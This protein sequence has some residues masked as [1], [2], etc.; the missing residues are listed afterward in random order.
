M[1]QAIIVHL[2]LLFHI[3]VHSWSSRHWNHPENYSICPGSSCQPG[4]EHRELCHRQ[5]KKKVSTNFAALLVRGRTTS[6]FQTIAS[7]FLGEKHCGFWI[8]W[9]P[10]MSYLKDTVSL[11]LPNEHIR[12]VALCVL[13]TQL[14]L[15]FCDPMDCNLSGSSVRGILQARMLEWVATPLSRGIVPTQGL[16][17]S[18]PHHGQILYRLSYQGS[19]RVALLFEVSLL[20][21]SPVVS[22]VHPRR[23]W[24]LPLIYSSHALLYYQLCQLLCKW[25][26]ACG[27][28]Y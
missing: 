5:K 8:F 25:L 21:P 13:V 18:L 20:F 24:F 4:I 17:Q 15:T 2:P 28:P 23:H 22:P 26:G 1:N 7:C 11:V 19:P 27:M 16:N 12:W 14:Y 3:V 6:S 10:E 9:Q